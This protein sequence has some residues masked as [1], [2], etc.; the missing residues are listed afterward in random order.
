VPQLSGEKSIVLVVE[1]HAFLRIAAINL[2]ENAGF[3]ALGAMS[4]DAAILILESRGDVRIVFTDVEMPGSM[5]G[6]ALAGAI[7]GRWPLIELIVT[8][9]HRH[10]G[11]AEIPDRGVFFRKPYVDG[12]VAA[13]L[14]RMAA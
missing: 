8:S 1:D 10:V 9:G 12:E 14:H 11:A 6:I 3:E 4:A 2:V 7:R 13:M 5:D